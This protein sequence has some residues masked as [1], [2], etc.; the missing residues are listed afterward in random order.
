MFGFGQDERRHSCGDTRIILKWNFW[1]NCS[2]LNIDF[3]IEFYLNSTGGLALNDQED[4]QVRGLQNVKHTLVRL[5]L[6]QQRTWLFVFSL[7]KKRS[8]AIPVTRIA[9]QPPMLFG[10]TCAAILT[11]FQRLPRSYRMI[12]T[13]I[14]R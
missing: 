2:S 3:A 4:H 14:R 10:K 1:K 11:I 12:Q 9:A 8:S 13:Y 5:N 6:F 7:S